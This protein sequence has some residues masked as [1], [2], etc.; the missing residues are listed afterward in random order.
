MAAGGFVKALALRILAIRGLGPLRRFAY[1]I[2][3]DY[4]S[5]LS[6]GLV[7]LTIRRALRIRRSRDFPVQGWDR[8][9]KSVV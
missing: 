6:A 5:V 2:A 9:R 7:E 4:R 8:D 3:L 1:R